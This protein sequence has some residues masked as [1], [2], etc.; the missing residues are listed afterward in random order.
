MAGTPI[1]PAYCAATMRSG[2]CSHR[3]DELPQVLG[4]HGDLVR[5]RNQ[6]ATRIER[7]LRQSHANG[8]RHALWR[9]PG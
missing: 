8:T 9:D 3:D 4:R 7:R 6:Y 1:V 5:Q 2:C